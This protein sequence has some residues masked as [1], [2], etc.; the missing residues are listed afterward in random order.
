M[1][2]SGIKIVTVT[3]YTMIAQ[4]FVFWQVCSKEV[5]LGV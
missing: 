4:A 5:I 1:T 2:C 3:Q